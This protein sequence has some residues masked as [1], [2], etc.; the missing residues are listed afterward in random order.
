MIVL[1]VTV[2][3]NFE[4]ILLNYLG[5]KSI[6]SNIYCTCFY[7]IKAQI[8]STN[9]IQHLNECSHE[10]ICCD[11]AITQKIFVN[12]LQGKMKNWL[13]NL[14]QIKELFRIAVLLKLNLSFLHYS[15][16]HQL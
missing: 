7:N 4:M 8:L 14:F 13:N 5:L 9:K 1:D 3:K 15:E 11:L 6:H 16:T 2:N 10:I 12:W